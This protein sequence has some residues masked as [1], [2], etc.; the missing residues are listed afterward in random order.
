M[1][2]TEGNHGNC[3]GRGFI[4]PFHGWRWDMEGR[5]IFVYGKHL[6]SERVLDAGEQ[7]MLDYRGKRMAVFGNCG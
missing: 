5:N 3:K 1:P 4:C 2:L 6:F 7:L